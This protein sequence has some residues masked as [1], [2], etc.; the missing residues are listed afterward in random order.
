MREAASRQA[1]LGAG[2]G[3][4]HGSRAVRAEAVTHAQVC[5]RVCFSRVA[6]NSRCHSAQTLLVC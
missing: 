4:V 3:S 2:G 5:F 6:A 1:L